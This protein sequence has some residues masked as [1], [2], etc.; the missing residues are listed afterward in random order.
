LLNIV[1]GTDRAV[2]LFANPRNLVLAWQFPSGRALAIHANLKT[3][4]WPG[5]IPYR[6][7]F[8]R[9]DNG[10]IVAQQIQTAALI[11]FPLHHI[12]ADGTVVRSFG[13]D[14]PEYRADLR[15][16][17][18]RVPAPS[19]DGSVWASA[20]GRYIIE[21]WD[22]LSGARLS[23]VPV[24]SSWFVESSSFPGDNRTRPRP[25]ILA[26]WEREALI[27]VLLQDAD[28]N[29]KP[30]ESSERLLDPALRNTKHDA[31]L[32]AV[33]PGT[34]N[35][36]ATRRFP[37]VLFGRPPQPFVV[38]YAFTDAGEP[39]GL[40]VWKPELRRKEKR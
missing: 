3:S 2:L 30:S 36:V 24:H 14:K 16:L 22:P 9:A 11:G 28:S 25:I 26:L 4:P 10:T 31:V 8:V 23:R 20:P 38:S 15:L 37:F 5:A 35:V 29:W 18:D 7:A 13:I 27:W 17:L 33:D 39:N 1:A 32:E 34:G 6:P 12:A 19:A 21:R 40:D